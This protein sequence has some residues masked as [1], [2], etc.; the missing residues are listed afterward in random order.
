MRQTR[1]HLIEMPLYIIL[2]ARHME[3]PAALLHL[4]TQGIKPVWKRIDSKD[5]RKA[6]VEYVFRSRYWP[7]VF[8]RLH[9]LTT[10][11]YSILVKQIFG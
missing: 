4:P 6:I 8:L 2:G 3:S 9:Q 11:R 5:S 10:T 7:M 1:F